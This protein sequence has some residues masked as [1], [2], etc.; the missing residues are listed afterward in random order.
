MQVSTARK[1][2]RFES[3]A[4]GTVAVLTLDA[5]PVLA[6]AMHHRPVELAAPKRA[7]PRF[8]VS[9]ALLDLAD[10]VRHALQQHVDLAP[11]DRRAAHSVGSERNRLTILA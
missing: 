9:P 8:H 6:R 11:I 4:R 1:H 7:D 10:L 3:Q 5:D 2:A